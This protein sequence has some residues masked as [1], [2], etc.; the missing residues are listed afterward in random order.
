MSFYVS[1]HGTKSTIETQLNST[2][3]FKSDYE[4]ALTEIPFNSNLFIDCGN[5]TIITK[6]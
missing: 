5:I 4:V 6:L 1:L 3:H 2:I